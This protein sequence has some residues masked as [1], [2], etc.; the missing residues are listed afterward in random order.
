MGEVFEAEQL[1]P[2]RRRTALKVLREGLSTD[3]ARARFRRESEALALMAHPSVATVFDCG[4][5][6]GGRPFLSM[7]FVD[8]VPITRY[9]MER[10]LPLSTRLELFL[11]VCEGVQHAHQRSIVHRDL[12]PSNI[13]VADRDD[14][15]VV[16]IID[17]GI[18]KTL[19]NDVPAL[20]RARQM[21]GTLEY[22]SPEQA[23]MAT[24]DI[25]TRTDI[26]SLGVVLY[27][28]LTDT[29]P[30]DWALI[31]EEGYDEIL[32]VYDRTPVAPSVRLSSPPRASAA[33]VDR[34]R[35]VRGDLDWV[36][37][38]ALERNHTQRYATVFELAADIR[39]FLMHEPVSVGPPSGAYRLRKFMR[40]YRLQV[41]ATLVVVGALSTGATLATVGMLRAR[42]AERRARADAHAAQEVV[43]F[44]GGLFQAADPNGPATEMTVTDLVA[45]GT[46]RVRAELTDQPDVRAQL[47]TTLGGVYRHL[48]QLDE[49]RAL[50]EEALSI[51]RTRLD[52]HDRR[53]VE[54]LSELGVSY[55]TAGRFEEAESVM[56]QCIE[57][58]Q[59]TDDD[60]NVRAF[61]HNLGVILKF[62]GSYPEAL[63]T[64][65]MSLSADARGTVNHAWTLADYGDALRLAGRHDDA[66]VV[67]Q[68]ALSQLRAALVED[69]EHPLIARSLLYLAET[70]EDMGRLDDAERA[71]REALRMWDE[72]YGPDH[73]ST[74]TALC[75]LGSTLLQR[76]QVAA[77]EAFVDECLAIRERTFPDDTWVVAYARTLKGALLMAQGD[78]ERADP[79]IREGVEQL[80]QSLPSGHPDLR[81]ALMRASDLSR[82]RHLSID[83]R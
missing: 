21:V 38:K 82:L 22:M 20:T 63:E 70:W 49:S 33:N 48:G 76:E 12:K 50:L 60:E 61:Q 78:L 30:F 18:A 15:V 62:R 39:R 75:G 3:E 23:R 58:A 32:R 4:V 17:F 19:G 74:A 59:R 37:L 29:L 40:R 13:L 25:D 1:V 44:L 9:C 55:L 51:R 57:W 10:D 71:Y 41:A 81:R 73:P 26:Y 80:R 5:T 46:H 2:V 83:E 72:R 24:R 27:E 66:I 53:S 77:A 45:R 8:G 6:P 43:D 34:A 79:L 65:R 68:D 35:E 64:L 7:E 56:R 69:A 36:A 42:N 14:R 52:E 47:L 11:S 31:R 16:K 54:T 67:Q 28:L